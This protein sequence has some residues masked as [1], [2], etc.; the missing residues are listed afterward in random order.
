MNSEA[1]EFI[2]NLPLP[3]CVVGAD[4]IIKAANDLMSEVILYKDIEGANFFTITGVKRSVIETSEATVD[5]E[6]ERNEKNFIVKMLGNA[7]ADED[8]TIIF[9]DVTEE[10]TLREDMKNSTPV[11]LM[12]SIDNYDELISSTTADSKRAVPTEVDRIVRK[13][14]DEYNAPILSSEEERYVILTDRKT[15]ERIRENNFSVLDEVRQIEAKVD[16]PVSLSIGM[17]S[18]NVSMLE[19]KALAEAARELALGRRSGCL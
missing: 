4:G 10:R 18:S 15:A 5:I 17:G 13:W 3:A 2:R 9:I 1:K 11:V 16:F 19:T 12:V 7:K 14:A 8:A 6:I